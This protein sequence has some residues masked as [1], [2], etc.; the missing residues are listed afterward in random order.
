MAVTT[1]PMHLPA[2]GKEGKAKSSV[3]LDLLVS[4]SLLPDSSTHPG[5]GPF[6]QIILQVHTLPGMSF[7]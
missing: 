2:R 5:G 7:S 6:P 1:M 4:G 3:L